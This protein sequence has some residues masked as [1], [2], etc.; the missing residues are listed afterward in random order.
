MS[1]IEV[2]D[3]RA[4]RVDEAPNAPTEAHQIA[5][6]LPAVPGSRALAAW[7]IASVAS[8][9]IVGEW[10][11]LALGNHKIL[12]AVPVVCAFGLMFYSHRQR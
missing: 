11:V 12:L 6:P 4:R 8:S 9:I 1:G 5:R 10:A 3:D 2:S 7:E